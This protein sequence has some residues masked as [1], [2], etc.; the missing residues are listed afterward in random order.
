M[1]LYTDGR[2]QRDCTRSVYGLLCIWP[3]TFR[4]SR[5]C[6]VRCWVWGR[7]YCMTSPSPSWCQECK[8]STE[9][10]ICKAAPWK[11]TRRPETLEG[12]GKRS[13][14]KYR[15]FCQMNWS[16][17]VGWRREILY[18]RNDVL[19]EPDASFTSNW[20]GTQV[21]RRNVGECLSHY[22]AICVEDRTSSV[23]GVFSPAIPNTGSQF[24]N[25]LCA[26]VHVCSWSVFFAAFSLLS[27]C[28]THC[29]FP[30]LDIH[31]PHRFVVVLL[32]LYCTLPFPVTIRFASTED[33]S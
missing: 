31:C 20:K 10:T 28:L 22:T 13:C 14:Q 23:E 25:Q 17:V 5:E 26:S 7:I 8:M 16:A 9:V 21:F 2:V 11:Q 24:V 1:I 15:Q 18:T 4:L 32:R 30:I 3:D 12:K 33:N 6:D 29:F 19:G 27:F